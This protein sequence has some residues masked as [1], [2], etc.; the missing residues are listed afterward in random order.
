MTDTVDPGTS[1]PTRT[2]TRGDLISRAPPFRST[3]WVPRTMANGGSMNSRGPPDHLPTGMPR[4]SSTTLRV[5][6]HH[7]LPDDPGKDPA[8][9]HDTVGPTPT[10]TSNASGTGTRS[11]PTPR[12]HHRLLRRRCSGQLQRHPGGQHGDVRLPLHRWSGA[13]LRHPASPGDVHPE[14]RLLYYITDNADSIIIL[15]LST[16]HR[17]HLPHTP[18]APRRTTT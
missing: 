5:H 7:L 8:W 3:R 1:Y 16:G 15:N 18:D 12:T 13:L 14:P 11:S 6:R 4:S 9:Y 2:T 10:T 17:V